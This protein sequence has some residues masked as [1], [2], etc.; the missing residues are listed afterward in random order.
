MLELKKTNI[1]A[2]VFVGGSS[3]GFVSGILLE[4]VDGC[5][6]KVLLGQNR[7]ILVGR[8]VLVGGRATPGVLHL[9]HEDKL[10]LLHLA[11]PTQTDKDRTDAKVDTATTTTSGDN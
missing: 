7:P 1:G 10:Q 4:A 5:D 8:N 6:P 2:E 9:L 3:V 11:T